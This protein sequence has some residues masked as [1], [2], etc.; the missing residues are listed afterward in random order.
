MISTIESKQQ[1]LINGFFQRG[2]GSEN[3]LVVGSCRTL[4]YLSYLIRYNE[5]IGNNR[6]T[7]RRID[8]CDWTVENVPLEPLEKDE[9]ILSAI[10]DVDIFIH[11][12]LSSYG[13]VNTDRNAENNIYQHGMSA[14]VDIAIPNFHD[15][16]ILENDY[17]AWGAPCPD[18]YIQ[19]G[20]DEVEKFC[21]VCE[22]SSFPEFGKRFKDTWRKIRYFWRPN[23]VSAKFTTYIFSA[24][25]YFFLKLPLTDEFWNAARQEDLFKNPHTEVSQRDREGYG[26]SWD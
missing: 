26:I 22:M 3:I 7:I 25:N 17:A 16:L 11:E 15:H 18:D 4:A 24:M 14:P 20:E 5:T 2:T 19:R 10:Q 6:F 8:P 13:L 1:Q 12:H 9:R 23:H 21:K